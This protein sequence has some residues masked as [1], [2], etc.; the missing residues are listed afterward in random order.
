MS[1]ELRAFS[2]QIERVLREEFG[3]DP[4]NQLIRFEFLSRSKNPDAYDRARRDYGDA[5]AIRTSSDGTSRLTYYGDEF[6]VHIEGVYPR[7]D[8]DGC[9]P[10]LEFYHP[11]CSIDEILKIA[12]QVNGWDALL[13]LRA[14]A[15]A[16]SARLTRV[17]LN[18]KRRVETGWSLTSHFDRRPFDQYVALLSEQDREKCANVA[19]GMAFLREPNGAC[20][21]YPVGDVL[22][23]SESLEWFLYYMNL[24]VA[25]RDEVPRQDALAALVLAVRTMLLTEAPDFDLDP[26]GFPPSDLDARCRGMVNDQILFIVGH[27]YA[28]LLLN[29]LDTRTAVDVPCGVMPTNVVP[30]DARYYSPR[31]WQEFEADAGSILHITGDEELISDLLNGATWFFLGLEIFYGINDYINPRTS[32]PKSHPDPV[33]RIW[34]LRKSVLQRHSLSSELSYSDAE[35][36]ELITSIQKIRDDLVREF[37]PFNVDELERYGSVYLPSF[38][39]AELIDRI[40]F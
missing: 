14:D 1:S 17:F 25:Y 29:H 5:L 24:F 31:Q 10:G 23:V 15:I 19:A 33:E 13:A 9:P 21:R 40:D 37:V 22:V 12:N 20:I 26:R 27:E 6:G 30:Q 16:D 34:A 38:R 7:S 4:V 3:L 2:S 18:R 36:E 28:H 11:I 35:I 39:P 8:L 32:A